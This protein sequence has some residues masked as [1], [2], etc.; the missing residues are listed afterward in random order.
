M[1]RYEPDFLIFASDATLLSL[2]GG[3]FV[4]LALFFMLM[5]RRRL[6]RAQINAVGWVPWNT[7]F[8]ASALVGGGLLAVALPVALRG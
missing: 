5:E 2:W 3:F 1:R 7:M 8:M 4:V 6:K